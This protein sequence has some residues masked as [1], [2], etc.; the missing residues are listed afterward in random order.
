M[1]NLE[2]LFVAERT[3]KI[4]IYCIKE[5]HLK[6]RILV[7]NI[8]STS[9]NVVSLLTCKIYE[10]QYVGS[11]VTKFSSRLNQC[12]SNIKLYGKVQRGFTQELQAVLNISFQIN[13]VVLIEI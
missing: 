4:A 5:I 12:R 9:R 2:L 3:V 1:K 11:T 10:N 13:I 6:V 8:K 7:S